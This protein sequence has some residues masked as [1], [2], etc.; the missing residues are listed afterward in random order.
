MIALLTA[1]VSATASSAPLEGE[2]LRFGGIGDAYVGDSVDDVAAKLG[3]TMAPP[4]VLGTDCFSTSDVSGN[5][6]L[7]HSS[8]SR[9]HLFILDS[10]DVSFHQLASDPVRVGSSRDEVEQSFDGQDEVALHSSSGREGNLTV[11]P[12]RLNNA[13]R[14]ANVSAVFR[15]D[16]SGHVRSVRLGDSRHVDALNGC[17]D[18]EAGPR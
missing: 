5:L 15:F 12:S 1:S 13:R 2:E 3:V 18:S 9:V 7:I 6:T 10:P 4:R 16:A 11:A 8:R 14:S 17:R